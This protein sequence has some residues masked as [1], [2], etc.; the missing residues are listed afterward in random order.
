[1]GDEII[2]HLAVVKGAHGAAVD[3]EQI[4]AVFVDEIEEP[5]LHGGGTGRADGHCC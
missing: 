3:A 4:D 5:T 2:A 1:M